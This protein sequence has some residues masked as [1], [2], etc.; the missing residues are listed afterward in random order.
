M[1]HKVHPRAFRLGYT[2][3]WKSRWFNKKKYKEFLKQDYKLR[4]F[5]IAKLK[6]T[7]IKE[8]EITRS[9]NLLNIKIY[10]AR[11]GIIIGRGGAGVQDLKREII[12]KIFKG[13]TKGLDIKIDIE[14]IRKPETHAEI[15]AQNI[16][17]QLERRRPFRRVIKQTLDKVIQ[18]PDVKGV[19]I[20]VAGRLG[21]TEMARQEWLRKGKVPL[22]TLRADINYAYINAYTTYGVIGVKVWVYKGEKFE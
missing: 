15:I 1:S 22:Q 21:G 16:A 3:D 6:Q 10:T 20:S 2:A 5:I 8:I 14:E 18:D 11:P 9:A 13:Q 4:E 17:E 7:A 12:S 19:K